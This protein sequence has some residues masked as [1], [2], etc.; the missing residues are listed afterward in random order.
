M[1]YTFPVYDGRLL[2]KETFTMNN[3]P[4]IPYIIG[5]T[6]HDMIPFGLEITNKSWAKKAYSIG[7]P[8]YLYDFDRDLPGDDKGTWHCC[9]M[10]YVFSTLGISWRPFEE[11]DYKLSKIMNKMLCNFA[12][13]GNP[14]CDGL[15]YWEA[16]WQKVMRL[17][18]ECE[19]VNWETKKF[20]MN[21]VT[22]KG[23]SI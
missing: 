12:K 6:T 9:D 5:M 18:K 21:T 13:T 16:N 17:N 20:F 2:K 15:P 4:D 19:L 23:T 22:G 10:L 3:I 14:N 7:S 11:D 8:C 1:P